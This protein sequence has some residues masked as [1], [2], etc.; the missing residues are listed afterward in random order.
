MKRAYGRSISFFTEARGRGCQLLWLNLTTVRGDTFHGDRLTPDFAELRRRI[1]R[2][3]GYE[4]AYFKVETTEGGG[5]L[6]VVLA[7]E[8]HTPVWIGQRW[9]SKQWQEIHGA[10]RVWIS[11]I[12]HKSKDAR[13]VSKY[14]VSQYMAGGQGSAF[15]RYSYSWWRCRVALGKGWHMLKKEFN[16]LRREGDR[17]GELLVSWSELLYLGTCTLC[18]RGYRLHDREVQMLAA[19]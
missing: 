2:K 11:R 14:L 17:F 12:G 9:L 15:K 19:A 6:H 7:I 5:V 1:E 13:G 16:L 18:G 4:L 8:S 3:Y 10:H